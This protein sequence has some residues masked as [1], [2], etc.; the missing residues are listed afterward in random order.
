MSSLKQTLEDAGLNFEEIFDSDPDVLLRA[1]C[2]DSSYLS[3]V[4]GATIP[5]ELEE[6]AQAK[7]NLF[8]IW[9]EENGGIQN[10]GA[11]WSFGNGA[12]GATIG[13]PVA[14]D[15]QLVAVTF[16]AE[17][18]GTSLTMSMQRNASTVYTSNHA[19]NNSV[20]TLVTPV[21]YDAG[22]TIVFRTGTL[23]GAFSDCRVCAWFREK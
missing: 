7:G 20:D 2:G 22:D 9:A 23:T 6:A 14:V 10:N 5:P 3:T 12:V 8:C 16:N 11:E 13:I 1:L 4:E 19:S 17:T 18:F 21:D 15:C